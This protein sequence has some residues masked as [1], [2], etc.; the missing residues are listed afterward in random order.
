MGKTVHR[1][2]GFE[3][4]FGSLVDRAK[5]DARIKNKRVDGG[6]AK[7]FLNRVGKASHTCEARQAQRQHVVADN[8]FAACADKESDSRSLLHLLCGSQPNASG[9]TCHDDCLHGAPVFWE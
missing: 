1:E 3:T 5:R 4:I 2:G 8:G 6:L 7:P 9:R